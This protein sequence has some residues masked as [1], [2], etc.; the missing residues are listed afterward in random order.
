MYSP[1][2]GMAN[3]LRQYPAQIWKYVGPCRAAFTMIN[4]SST[5]YTI[6]HS[7]NKAVHICHACVIYDTVVPLY[8]MN[9]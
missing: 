7:T 3:A 8:M 5:K 9:V 2:Y 6:D 1:A 4:V